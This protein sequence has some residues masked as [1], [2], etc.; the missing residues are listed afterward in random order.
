MKLRTGIALCVILGDIALFS[1]AGG[2]DPGCET[3][4]CDTYGGSASKSFGNCYVSGVGS[5]RPGDRRN[6][7]FDRSRGPSANPRAAK[8]STTK[9]PQGLASHFNRRRSRIAKTT[10]RGVTG[11]F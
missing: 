11:R 7:L 8:S 2:C 3:V 9:G 10:H 5:F 6:R 1:S 4:T